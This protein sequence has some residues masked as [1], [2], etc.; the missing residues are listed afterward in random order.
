MVS[1]ARTMGLGRDDHA[2]ATSRTSLDGRM[3]Q[4]E[5]QRKE[6]R[7]MLWWEV[8]FYDL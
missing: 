7:R 6:W 3:N 8:M 5:L 4:R 2:P 1:A